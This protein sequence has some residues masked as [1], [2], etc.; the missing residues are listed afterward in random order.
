MPDNTKEYMGHTITLTDNWKF[1]VEGPEFDKTALRYK[2]TFESYEAACEEIKTRINDTSRVET[3]NLRLDVQV[4]DEKGSIIRLERINRSSGK[5]AGVDTRY[6]YPNFSWIRLAVT[7][8]NTLRKEVEEIDKRLNV[9]RMDT[10]RSYSRISAN[11]YAAAMSSFLKEYE[12]KVK[13]AEEASAPTL[14][15]ASDSESA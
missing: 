7:K 8:L 10:H 15:V 9:V 2:V 1:T 14:V 13:K 11:G 4:V 3:L 6:V 12:E 5:V